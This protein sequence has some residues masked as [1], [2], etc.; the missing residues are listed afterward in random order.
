[1]STGNY[2]DHNNLWT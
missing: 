2:I 1:M